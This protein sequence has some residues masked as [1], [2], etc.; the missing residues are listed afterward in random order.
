[1]PAATVTAVTRVCLCPTSDVTTLTKNWHHSYSCP[2][3]GKDLSNDT[4]I[5]VTGSIEPELCTKNAQK[6]ERKTTF[7]EI[8][9]LEASSG[10][11]Q[12]IQQKE[13]EKE[14]MERQKKK[15]MKSLKT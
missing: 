13:N 15:N 12:P 7:S 11:G 9:E 6:F 10:E 14:K 8:L 5:R 4:Q 2:V 3:G 1:M